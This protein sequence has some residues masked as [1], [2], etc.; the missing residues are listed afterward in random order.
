MKEYLKIPLMIISFL[1]AFL[2]SVNVYAFEVEIDY[3]CNPDAIP[4]LDR[5]AAAAVISNTFANAEWMKLVERKQCTIYE[6]P[7][8]SFLI[9]VNRMVKEYPLKDVNGETILLIE[10]KGTN[11]FLS[12]ALWFKSTYDQHKAKD[13]KKKIGWEI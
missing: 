1:T 10:Y 6:N 3:A 7:Y 4:G 9:D 5:V 13:V 8:V 11:G 12:Y 2:L